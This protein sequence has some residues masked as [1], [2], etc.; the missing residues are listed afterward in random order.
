MEEQES[1]IL[2]YYSGLDG[3]YCLWLGNALGFYKS[4]MAP[5]L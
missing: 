1:F 3:H 2:S 5:W 4:I